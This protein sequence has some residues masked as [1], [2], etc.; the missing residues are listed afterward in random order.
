MHK[1]I[2]V[3]MVKLP[4]DDSNEDWELLN[5]LRTVIAYKKL[6]KDPKRLEQ[7]KALALKAKTENVEI[8]AAIDEKLSESHSEYEEE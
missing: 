8:V 6:C 4:K 2:K 5:D 1:P 3:K 7:I